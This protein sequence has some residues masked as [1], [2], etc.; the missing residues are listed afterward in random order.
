MFGQTENERNYQM[1]G[2]GLEFWDVWVA[3]AEYLREKEKQ[4]WVWWRRGLRNYTRPWL[5]V[6]RGGQE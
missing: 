5:H 2:L 4:I 6:T 3:N 1:E